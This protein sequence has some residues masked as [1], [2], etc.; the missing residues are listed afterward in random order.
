MPWWTWVDITK[1]IDLA[2]SNLTAVELGVGMYAVL[3]CCLG[4]NFFVFWRPASAAASGLEYGIGLALDPHALGAM[5][6]ELLRCIPNW[7]E[8]PVRCTAT[9][10]VR[11]WS[12]FA[13]RAPSVRR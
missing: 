12:T 10:S 5:T 3:E 4:R 11:Y 9:N 2:H 1:P 6:D 7:H 13:R 8:L